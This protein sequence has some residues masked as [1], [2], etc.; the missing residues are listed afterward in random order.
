MD[1]NEPAFP[2][3]FNHSDVNQERYYGLSKRE[4]FAGMAMQGIC[5]TNCEYNSWEDLAKDAIGIADSLIK[6]LEK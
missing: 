4:Y 2:F 3:E 6:E 1:S 5:A